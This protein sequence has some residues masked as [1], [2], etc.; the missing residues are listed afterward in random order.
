M[1]IP[2]VTG[3]VEGCQTKIINGFCMPKET[4]AVGLRETTRWIREQHRNNGVIEADAKVVY[5]AFHVEPT[6]FSK[7]GIII[8]EGRRLLQGL[9][10]SI[11]HVK[12]QANTIA[13]A[14]AKA[15]AFLPAS[16]FWHEV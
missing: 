5:D 12:R 13:D 1:T 6:D 8:A 11:R 10:I 9:N 2:S 16:C 4:E 15:A 3:E 7:F 14:L